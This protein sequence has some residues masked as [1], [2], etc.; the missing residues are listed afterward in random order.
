MAGHEWRPLGF[1]RTVHFIFERGAIAASWRHF[2]WEL[3]IEKRGLW[4]DYICLS[5]RNDG[6]SDG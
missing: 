4:P 1:R 3:E 5:R 2:G 6:N